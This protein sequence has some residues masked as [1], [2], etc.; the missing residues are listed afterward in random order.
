MT[1]YDKN[2]FA[3]PHGPG[4]HC[5]GTLAYPR[6]GVV[7]CV[8]SVSA[9]SSRDGGPQRPEPRV[10]LR[11]I[12]QP[13][14]PARR[15]VRSLRLSMRGL[16]RFR[17]GTRSGE[18]EVVELERSRRAPIGESSGYAAGSPPPCYDK[19]HRDLEKSTRSD[20][21][22]TRDLRPSGHPLHRAASRSIHKSSERLEQEPR[23]RSSGTR[24]RISLSSAIPRR[25]RPAGR[26]SYECKILSGPPTDPS[27]AGWNAGKAWSCLPAI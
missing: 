4:A 6:R 2:E 17:I 24:I 27:K 23:R 7:D 12:V 5:K 20:C 16:L 3:S 25:L 15:P 13:D 11:R 21:R 8:G 9:R 1:S 19:P 18:T 26:C 10:A 22:S 14:W